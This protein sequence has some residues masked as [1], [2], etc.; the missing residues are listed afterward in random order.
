[1][2]SGWRPSACNSTARS[3]VEEKDKIETKTQ[4]TTVPFPLPLDPSRPVLDHQVRHDVLLQADTP[5]V[6]TVLRFVAEA[7]DRCA[8]GAQTGRSGVLA[9]QVVSPDEL[10]Y[11]ILIR[12]RAERTKFLAVLETV[13]KQT[14]V[15]AGNPTADDFLRVMRDQHSGSRQLD[16]IA[17]RIADTLQ[18]MKLNQIGSPKSH[19][20]LQ[21]GVIDPMRALTAGSMNQLRGVLQALAGAASNPGANKEAARRLHGE[22]V[23]KMR[24]IL[25]QMS[26]WESFVDVVNQVAEVIRM[27]Q[28]VLQATEKARETRT[29]EVFDD[30]P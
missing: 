4:R 27:E 26:Q 19:R 11:E 25:E 10:F 24:N 3:T 5:K 9:L 30:K 21:E 17:G 6:G 14:P 13:D 8:R 18:E 29:Q 20:L 12:Q 15:L 28:K 1:M 16:Q 22:V 7:D 2:I 23:T